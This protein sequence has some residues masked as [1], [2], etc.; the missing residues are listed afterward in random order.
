MGG[1]AHRRRDLLLVQG[2]CLAGLA[3]VVAVVYA[4]VV[5]GIGS[6]PTSGQWT[7]LAFSMLAAAVVAL[8]YV[9]LRRRLLAA[10]DW[11]VRAEQAWGEDLVR[12]FG[13]RAA[14]G[15][16][17]DELLLQLAESLRQALALAR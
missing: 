15:L 5:L 13:G 4:L 11:L 8:I 6:V 12:A 7:L 10:G 2:L 1:G 9:P 17:I 3:V 16:P 14:R